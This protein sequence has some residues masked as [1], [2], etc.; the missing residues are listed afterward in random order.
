MRNRPRI[1]VVDD[2]QSVVA[3]LAVLLEHAGYN[4][5]TAFDA[6]DGLRQAYEVHPDLILLDVNLPDRDGFAVL[7]RLR[8]QTDVPILMLTAR[9]VVEDRVRGLDGGAD[10]YILKPFESDELL[11]R[12]RRHLRDNHRRLPNRNM[13]VVD[14][15]LTIDYTA[16]HLIVDGVQVELTPIE[17]KILRELVDAEGQIVTTKDLLRAGWGPGRDTDGGIVKV[18]IAALRRKIGDRRHPSKYIHTERE[19]GYRFEPVK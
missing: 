13:Y 9:T 5:S 14:D 4:L 16:N 2:D 1:L 17:W 3:A 15:H 11:A 8:E 18:R 6:L 7:Q 19:V 10:D 12:I